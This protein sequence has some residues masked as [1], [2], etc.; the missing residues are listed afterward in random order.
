MQSKLIVVVVL[1]VCGTAACRRMAATSSVSM[2]S[3]D[4]LAKFVEAEK[5]ARSGSATTFFAPPEHDVCPDTGLPIVGHMNGKHRVTVL[6]GTNGPLSRVTDA[7]G[8]VLASSITDEDFRIRFPEMGKLLDYF[9]KEYV[10][11]MKK[12]QTEGAQPTPAK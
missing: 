8:N 2:M 1:C 3:S 9:W 12:S 6:T 11:G 4:E 10:P 5:K 7:S